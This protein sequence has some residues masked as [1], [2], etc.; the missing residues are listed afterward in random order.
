LQCAI[1]L[2]QLT[3]PRSNNNNT[4]TQNSMTPQVKLPSRLRTPIP[5]PLK[6]HGHLRFISSTP[7][8]PKG[9][10]V[11]KPFKVSARL[12]PSQVQGH[13]KVPF[14]LKSHQSPSI[15]FKA[16]AGIYCEQQRPQKNAQS[17]YYITRHTNYTS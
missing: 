1:I 10:G 6:G 9:E 15:F 16:Q 5:R 4:S 11:L 7:S 13:M 12:R 2:Q 14:R 3:K 17:N 8:S